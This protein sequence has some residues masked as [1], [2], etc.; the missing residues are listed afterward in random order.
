LIKTNLTG[1]TKTYSEYL[2]K[3]NNLEFI[4][5]GLD[6]GTIKLDEQYYAFLGVASDV[7]T[8]DWV[9]KVGAGIGIVAGSIALTPLTGGASWGFTWAAL[10]YFAGGSALGGVLG[11]VLVA[12]VI[13]GWDG[14]DSFPPSLIEA[15]SEEYKSLKCDEI[16]TKS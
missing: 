3:T 14:K 2:Y 5:G 15:N 8:F 9:W 4:S 7:G 10:G 6:F 13:K 11:G 1:S 16:V 12:P